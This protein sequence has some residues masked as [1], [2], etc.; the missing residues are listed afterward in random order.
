MTEKEL[1]EYF[2]AGLVAGLKYYSLW[3]LIKIILF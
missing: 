3:I 1:L 2:M